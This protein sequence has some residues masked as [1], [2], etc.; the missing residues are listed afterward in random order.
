LTNN[1][2][3]V[4]LKCH[5]FDKYGRVLADIY[6]SSEHGVSFSQILLAEGLAKEYHGGKKT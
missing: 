2:Y 5:K 6:R 4:W 3:L 1:V